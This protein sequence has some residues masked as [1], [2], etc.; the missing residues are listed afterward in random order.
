MVNF[1]SAIVGAGLVLCT[2]ATGVFAQQDDCVSQRYVG[3]DFIIGGDPC[4][5]MKWYWPDKN[6]PGT[7]FS[8]E[9]EGCDA[10][11]SLMG[12]TPPTP[13]P[14][15]TPTPTVPIDQGECPLGAQSLDQ[16]IPGNENGAFG[17]SAVTFGPNESKYFCSRL[18]TEL[19]NAKKLLYG[20]SGRDNDHTCESMMVEVVSVPAESTADRSRLATNE[21]GY[22]SASVDVAFYR[23]DADV[24]MDAPPG[25][26]VIKATELFGERA[27]GQQVCRTFQVYKMITYP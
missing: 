22:R 16:P 9:I 15:P 24:A 5:Q 13:T 25:W 19:G 26:Y 6:C 18:P 27:P 1:K 2:G 8:W 20:F 10:L 12:G 17:L 11:D 4:G 21:N 3:G 23:T 7:G 14:G